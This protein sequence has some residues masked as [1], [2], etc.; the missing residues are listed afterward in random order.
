MILAGVLL[1]LGGFGFLRLV[2]PR[3]PLKPGST[4]GGWR[5]WLRWRSSLAPLALLARMISSDW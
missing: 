5:R 1:K 2:L 3:S 4:P